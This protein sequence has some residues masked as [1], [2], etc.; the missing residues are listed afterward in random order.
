MDSQF[1]E[2]DPPDPDGQPLDPGF[3]M[4]VTWSHSISELGSLRR[5]SGSGLSQGHQQRAF[6]PSRQLG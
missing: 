1:I 5:G 3:Q 6:E 2:N 4:G